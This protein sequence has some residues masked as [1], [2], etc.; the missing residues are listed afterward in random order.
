MASAKH[1]QHGL[2]GQGNAATGALTRSHGYSCSSAVLRA[3][4]CPLPVLSSQQFQHVLSCASAQVWGAVWNPY[5]R[6]DQKGDAERPE[7][8]EFVTYGVK[9]VA[10]WRCFKDKV[11]R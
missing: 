6:P 3:D 5:I 8:S 7:W 9:H 4:R 2:W 11:T 10:V 1:Y